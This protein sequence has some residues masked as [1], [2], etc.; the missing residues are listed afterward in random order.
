M[1]NAVVMSNS[2]PNLAGERMLAHKWAGMWSWSRAT[3]WSNSSFA[4]NMQ[5]Q[6]E[7]Q[8]P[9][10]KQLTLDA[11]DKLGVFLIYKVEVWI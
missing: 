6:G 1:S 5:L 11:L 2:M 10:R 9:L 8:L 4:L 7:Q 3:E